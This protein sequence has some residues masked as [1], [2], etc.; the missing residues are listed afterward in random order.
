M[1]FANFVIVQASKGTR[2]KKLKKNLEKK[3][4]IKYQ[5]NK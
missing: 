1:A 3:F 4:F 5:K 2:V